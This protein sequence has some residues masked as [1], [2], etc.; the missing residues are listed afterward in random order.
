MYGN[1]AKTGMATIV[2][3][4][5]I[6]LKDH[7]PAL[8]AWIAAAAGTAALRAAGCRIAATVVRAAVAT[9][10]ASA[11]SVFLSFNTKIRKLS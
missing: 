3:M 1:G 4:T 9:T 11:S 2:R 6:I 5:Q 8:A 7:P 10:L